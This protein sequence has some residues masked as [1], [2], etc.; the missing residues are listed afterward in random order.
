M[1]RRLEGRTAVILGASQRGGCGL[2]TAQVLAAEGA[3]VFV[4]DRRLEKVQ[5]LAAEIGGTA[6]RCDASKEAEV[7]DC[8]DAAAERSGR[9]DIAVEA[10]GEGAMGSIEETGQDVLDEAFAG[11]YIGQIGRAHG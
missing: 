9:I 10:V 5:E 4:A 8:V 11:Y 2:V 6:I 1:S 3:Q 7:R